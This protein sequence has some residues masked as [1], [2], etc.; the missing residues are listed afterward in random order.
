M[1]K[2]EKDIIIYV[3][4][5]MD[6]CS[7]EEKTGWREYV[8]ERWEGTILDPCRRTLTMDDVHEVVTMDKLDIG[9]ADV[10]LANCWKPGWG[11]AMEIPYAFERGKL[12]VVVFPQ[13]HERPV[14]PWLKYH[15]QYVV[16][17][18]DIALQAIRE[19]YG[20]FDNSIT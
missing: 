4:G 20:V 11:T 19:Y 10:V 9:Q 12:V 3:A 8:K 17:S 15:S 18:I 2:R 16:S 13:L 1:I 5:P 14:S 7:Q 6:F